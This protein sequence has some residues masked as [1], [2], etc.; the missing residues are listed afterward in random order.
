MQIIIKDW[1]GNEIDTAYN[2]ES[3]VSV[4]YG[5]LS[6]HDG[7]AR[8]VTCPASCYDQLQYEARINADCYGIPLDTIRII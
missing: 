5:D 2:I 7:H 6:T 8:Q 4:L 1:Q 3:A